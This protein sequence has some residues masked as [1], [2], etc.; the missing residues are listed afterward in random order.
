M[1]KKV[2]ELEKNGVFHSQWSALMSQ[3]R[4]KIGLAIVLLFV[5]A[6]VFAPLI[7]P[8][9]PLLVDV[10]HKLE[11]PSSTYWLG[12]DQ[13]GRCIASRLLW[14]GRNSL[15][16]GA[17]VLVITLLVGV[18]IGLISGYVGG[19][20][21]LF[22]MRVIDIFMAMPSFIVALAIAGTLGASGKN[23]VLSMSFVYWAGYA[24]LSRALT[25]QVKEQ[26][27][28]MALKAGG[29]G[30]TRIIF[31]HV[32]R[33]I[34]PSIIAL[35]T[36]EIGTII[37]AIAG[38]SF[39]GLGVQPP[40]PEWGIM[41]SDSKNFIQTFPQLMIYPG[42]VIVIVVMA[43]NLLGEGMKNGMAGE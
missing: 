20:T 35:A 28:M 24:R 34:A 1:K 43:F 37:L 12:T 10:S 31:R 15:L 19:K 9:D 21:D 38:F 33:N 5:A 8:N 17:I 14:G 22:F 27:Y 23:L 30:H 25:I 3:T 29:C 32:L 18:P 42:I 7:A 6:A 40:T 11:G 4:S 26:N 39:I 16:Y 36:M 41:L 2:K 13:L